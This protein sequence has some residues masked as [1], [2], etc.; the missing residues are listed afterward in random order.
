[1]RILAIHAFACRKRTSCGVR[2]FVGASAGRRFL[3]NAEIPAD[4]R[5]KG[6]IS[7]FRINRCAW[8]TA[9]CRSRRLERLLSRCGYSNG[10]APPPKVSVCCGKLLAGDLFFVGLR[11]EGSI[12]KANI[13]SMG[14]R[15]LPA[16]FA[17]ARGLAFLRKRRRQPFRVRCVPRPP[18]AGEKSPPRKKKVAVGWRSFYCLRDFY[19]NIAVGGRRR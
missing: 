19:I 10:V 1:M 8:A 4:N 15:H 12:G 14:A 16:R 7:A 13:F 9:F 18:R 3:R 2:F 11:R 17:P 5:R 6:E